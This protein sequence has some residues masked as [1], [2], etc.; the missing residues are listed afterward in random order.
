MQKNQQS[1]LVQYSEE[2]ILQPLSLFSL[3]TVQYDNYMV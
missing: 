1:S 2:I 3:N